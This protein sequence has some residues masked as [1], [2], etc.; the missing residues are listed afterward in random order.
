MVDESDKALFR[1][2]VA[3]AGVFDKDAETLGSNEKKFEPFKAYSY[4]TD[5]TL[6]GSD[7]L[8]YAKSG[9]SKKNI[10]QMKRGRIEHA[11][12]LD[13]HGQSIVEACDSMSNFFYHQQNQRYVQI[14]HG[15]GYHSDEGMSVIKTQVVS[16][17]KQHPQVLAFESCPVKDGGTGAVF[18]LLKKH[19]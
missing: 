17:L 6:S 15:K 11:P 12:V 10:Q 4:I 1:Q 3:N 18:V 7:T 13:L 9:V 5:A 14:I 2:T 19:V 8:S 16:F